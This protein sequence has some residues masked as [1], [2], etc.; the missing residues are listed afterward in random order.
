MQRK[1]EENVELVWKNVKK[2][3]RMWSFL[4]KGEGQDS[5]RFWQNNYRGGKPLYSGKREKK[6]HK[7]AEEKGYSRNSRD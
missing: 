5:L 6:R 1:Y 3:W 7:G 4:P 2:V